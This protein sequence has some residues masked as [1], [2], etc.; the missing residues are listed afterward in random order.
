MCTGRLAL[1][2]FLT[3]MM[4]LAALADSDHRPD[5]ERFSAVV[6]LSDL[7]LK[8]PAGA[9]VAR[10]RIRKA[11]LRLCRKFSDSRRVSDRQTVADCMQQTAY[12]AASTAGLEIHSP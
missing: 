9:R 12:A 11:A 1:L 4:P 7:N 5:S 3:T 8:T 6:T 10:D 2:I